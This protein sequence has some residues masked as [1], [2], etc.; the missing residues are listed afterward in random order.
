MKDS[1][2]G[3]QYRA[4][5]NPYSRSDFTIFKTHN[6]RIAERNGTTL[7]L[8]KESSYIGDDPEYFSEEH[9][10]KKLDVVAGY[11]RAFESSQAVK[12]D[13]GQNKESDK[14]N[15][16]LQ[17]PLFTSNPQK[18]EKVKIDLM[19]REDLSSLLSFN[20]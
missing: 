11:N 1:T 3:K 6:G 20:T 14:E 10:S 9:I 2:P 19:C 8:P 18:P 4:P 12:A 13:A 7:F 5:I 17:P 15:K 16:T